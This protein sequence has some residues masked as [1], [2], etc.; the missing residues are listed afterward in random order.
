MTIHKMRLLLELNGQKYD[1]SSQWVSGINLTYIEVYDNLSKSMR[2]LVGD[3][4]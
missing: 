4:K 3:L 1:V 2:R